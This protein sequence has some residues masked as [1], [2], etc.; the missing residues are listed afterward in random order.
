MVSGK[1]LNL[2]Y[3][4]STFLPS[5]KDAEKTTTIFEID[6]VKVFLGI[7]GFFI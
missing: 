4:L 5:F 1:A 3:H 6:K 2:L 7:L